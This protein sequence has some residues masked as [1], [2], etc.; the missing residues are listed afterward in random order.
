MTQTEEQAYDRGFQTA[1]QTRS[2]I[3]RESGCRAKSSEGHVRRLR[4]ALLASQIVAA[5]FAFATW[6][7][8]AVM[9]LG[10]KR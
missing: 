4:R 5:V 8:L 6:A 1:L 10:A 3:A 9:L 2:R 7:L